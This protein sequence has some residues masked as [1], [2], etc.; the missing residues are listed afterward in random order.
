MLV[1]CI[2]FFIGHVALLIV[3]IAFF[4]GGFGLVV[5]NYF[6][7]VSAHHFVDKVGDGHQ[8]FII[9]EKHARVDGLH[10]QAEL[11]IHLEPRGAQCPFHNPCLFIQTQ[12]EQLAHL[13]VR[14]SELLHILHQVQQLDFFGVLCQAFFRQNV[15]HSRLPFELH[16][17]VYSVAGDVQPNRLCRRFG[18][19]VCALCKSSHDGFKPREEHVAFVV[20]FGYLRCAQA[21]AAQSHAGF[22]LLQQL[23]KL[24]REHFCFRM[25]RYGLFIFGQ[26]LGHAL[27]KHSMCAVVH[28]YEV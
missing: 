13:V 8:A 21:R 7:L 16:P 3:R 11:L 14:G 10:H 17:V 4:I 6:A 22:L 26:N 9:V 25:R 18:L 19:R 24:R 5:R 28:F 15:E 27:H 1:G 20:G 12:V 2:A 23:S